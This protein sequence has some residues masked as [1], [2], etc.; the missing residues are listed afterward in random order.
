MARWL[1]TVLILSGMTKFTPHSF[2]G[3][4]AAAAMFKSG[5]AVHDT[6][7]VAGCSGFPL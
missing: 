5:V 3:A 1:K 6:M 2:R 7:K 4:S